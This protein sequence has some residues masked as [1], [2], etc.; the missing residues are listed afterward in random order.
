M[1]KKSLGLPQKRRN[2]LGN[3][4]SVPKKQF[5]AGNYMKKRYVEVQEI[6]M[7]KYKN[8]LLENPEKKNFL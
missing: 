3:E 6:G 1:I 4:I 5:F 7:E 2:H 8:L